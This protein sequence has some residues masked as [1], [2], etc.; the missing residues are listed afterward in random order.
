[1]KK[2]W[3]CL[4]GGIL[5]CCVAAILFH[6]VWACL[7]GRETKAEVLTSYLIEYPVVCH[8]RADL[9]FNIYEIAV[10]YA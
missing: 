3:D 10:A 9:F 7:F 5:G 2:I 4:L 1:M 8:Y 6:G